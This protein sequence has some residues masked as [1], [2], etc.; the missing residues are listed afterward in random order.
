MSSINR[1]WHA[2]HR[3]GDKASADERIAWHLEHTAHCR[4]RPIPAGVLKLM[5]S[6][7]I[8]LPAAASPPK[9]QS[10]RRPA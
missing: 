10:P 3:L 4:C 7:G 1:E 6:R 5:A 8:E 9:R 2:T